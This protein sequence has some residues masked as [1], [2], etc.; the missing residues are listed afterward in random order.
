MD[1]RYIPY[2][3]QVSLISNKWLDEKLPG[4]PGRKIESLLDYGAELHL[5]TAD[6]T[7]MPYEG[8]IEVDFKLETSSKDR[9]VIIPKLVTGKTLDHPIIEYNAIKELVKRQDVPEEIAQ[10]WAASFP[11]TQLKNIQSIVRFMQTPSQDNCLVR[12]IEQDMVIPSEDYCKCKV[13]CKYRA[14]RREGTA[15]LQ[16]W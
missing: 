12:T 9:T 14:H 13:S 3:T 1:K 7:N 2:G 11:G 8:W 10:E 6:R 16:T 5:K 4:I 15:T